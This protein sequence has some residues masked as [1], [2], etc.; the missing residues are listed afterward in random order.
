MAL[1]ISKD[2]VKMASRSRKGYWRMAGNR[3]V[4]RALTKQWLWDQ[5]VPNIRQHPSSPSATPGQGGLTFIIP[6]LR[7]RRKLLEP[8]SA[9]PHAWWCGSRDWPHAVS[10]RPPDYASVIVWRRHASRTLATSIS[11]GSSFHV[12]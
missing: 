5:G 6:R 8:P 1:G 3:I 7:A 12:E 4:E 2:D 9:D 10:H 11:S